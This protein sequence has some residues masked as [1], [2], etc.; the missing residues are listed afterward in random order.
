MNNSPTLTGV[1]NYKA[2][3]D[4]KLSIRV[5][6]DQAVSSGVCN[7]TL[8]NQSSGKTVAKTAQTVQNPSSA[9]CMGFDV[10]LAELGSGAWNIV[11]EITGDG[12]TGKITGD[13]NL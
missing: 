6:I 4:D 10:P 12:K 11:I 7:L 1:L 3:V 2:V 8:T 9:S 5:T 13:I